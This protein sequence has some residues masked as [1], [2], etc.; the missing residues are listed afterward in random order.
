M[1]RGF[2]S[3]GALGLNP[4]PYQLFDIGCN[5]MDD[6]FKGQYNGK[7]RHEDDTEMVLQRAKSLGVQTIICT[8]GNIQESIDTLKSL[9]RAI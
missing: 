7:K 8:A 2:S 4:I 6:M 5:L 9:G 3:T 1:L